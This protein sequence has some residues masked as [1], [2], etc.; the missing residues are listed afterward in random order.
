MIGVDGD[1]PRAVVTDPPSPE[2][3]GL[4]INMGD[5]LLNVL[6]RFLRSI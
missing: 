3:V 2:R 1:T 6:L 5:L 4:G